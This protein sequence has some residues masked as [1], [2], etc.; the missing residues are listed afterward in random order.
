MMVVIQ[1]AARKRPEAGN[2]KTRDGRP[3]FFVADP[4]AAPVMEGVQY[5]R[6]DDPADNGGTWRD[7]LLA[8]NGNDNGNPV[9][10]LPACDLY[11]NG[12]YRRLAAEL[13]RERLFILS[14]GWGLIA[15]SFLTPSYDI[16]FT[17][18]A[19]A[20]KRRR[21]GD[22][23]QDFSMLPQATR[24]PVLF[25]GGKDYLPLF[26]RLTRGV[27]A[28]RIVF[29][30]SANAPEISSGRAV[31]FVTSTRT[32]WHYECV[33]AFLAGKLDREIEAQS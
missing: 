12:A 4:K 10:L 13:G 21:R 16:T 32:N 7:Q 18:Q 26:D 3:V 14:A 6:P 25:F 9:G 17:A 5:A 24:E 27:Q 20:Y 30:N 15:A 19:D 31:R 23:Y 1:C 22:R 2:L 8:Y 33:D 28:Q 11:E 29:F